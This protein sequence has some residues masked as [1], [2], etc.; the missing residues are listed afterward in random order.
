MRYGYSQPDGC[1]Y[2]FLKQCSVTNT[3]TKSDFDAIRG[4]YASCDVTQQSSDG[5]LIDCSG[6]CTTTTAQCCSS[7]TSCKTYNKHQCVAPKGGVSW[8]CLWDP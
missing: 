5:W 1:P 7:S 4:D 3:M 2:E 6:N 8:D